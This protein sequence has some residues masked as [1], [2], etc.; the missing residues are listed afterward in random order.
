MEAGYRGMT[1]TH[2]WNFEILHQSDGSKILEIVDGYAGVR[3]RVGYKSASGVVQ[4]IKSS[5]PDIDGNFNDFM[6]ELYHYNADSLR[7]YA[8]NPKTINTNVLST[9]ILGKWK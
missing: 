1:C 7:F 3:Q 2:Q 9:V 8:P 6:Q 5:V 4:T